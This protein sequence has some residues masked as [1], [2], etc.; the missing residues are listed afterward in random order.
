MISFWSTINHVFRHFLDSQENTYSLWFFLLIKD[1]TRIIVQVIV[2]LI[3]D[4]TKIIIEG[5]VFLIKYGTKIIV[6]VSLSDKK[7]SLMWV[8]EWLFLFIKDWTEIVLRFCSDI[9][10]L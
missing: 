1:W 9:N 10:S 5:I 7:W 8:N 2:F 4:G 3:K 6:Q